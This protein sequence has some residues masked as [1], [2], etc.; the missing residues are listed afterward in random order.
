LGTVP[1][2]ALRI[3]LLAL[4]ELEGLHRVGAALL[5][6]IVSGDDGEFIVML[7]SR[8]SSSYRGLFTRHRV[9]VG[10]GCTAYMKARSR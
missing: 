6:Y 7:N 1:D 5:A 8:R 10:R 9:G 2:T 4:L 3:V